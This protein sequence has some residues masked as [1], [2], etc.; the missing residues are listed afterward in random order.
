MIS[1]GITI[2][3]A[4]DNANVIGN[5]GKLSWKIP[6]DLKFFKHKTMGNSVV[7]GRKT[8]ESIPNKPLPGRMNVILSR[9]HVEIPKFDEPNTSA[10]VV[11]SIQKAIDVCKLE[12]PNKDIFIIGGAMVYETALAEGIVSHVLVSKVSGTH[13]GDVYFPI[14]GKDW[15][16][17]FREKYD[18]FTL[19]GY[20]KEDSE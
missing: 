9:G 7:M 15:F 17:Y 14:L 6:A 10:C 8:W 16:C 20:R 11:N 12:R 1:N 3:V 2:L 5:K 4:H 13:E 19:L 18:G